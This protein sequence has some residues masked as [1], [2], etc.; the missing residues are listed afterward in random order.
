MQATLAHPR[1][2]FLSKRYRFFVEP[3]LLTANGRGHTLLGVHDDLRG[4]GLEEHKLAMQLERMMGLK[5]T[6]M[7]K[8][9]N[10]YRAGRT[11]SL[12]PFVGAQGKG[13]GS[14]PVTFLRLLGCLD[15]LG[16]D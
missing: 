1:T 15:A 9:L 2:R 12:R 13:A 14:S 3:G 11:S 4:Q 7:H 10:E 16:E 8:Y 6:T 5:P